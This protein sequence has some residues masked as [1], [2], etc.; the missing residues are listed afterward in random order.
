MC[1]RTA[2][3][4]RVS[5]GDLLAKVFHDWDNVHGLALAGGGMVFGDGCLEHGATRELALGAARAGLDDVEVA[6][7]LGGQTAG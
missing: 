2:E 5:L 7:G 3:F 4:P 6:F 1:A